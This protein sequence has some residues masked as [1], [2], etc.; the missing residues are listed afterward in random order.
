MIDNKNQMF[1]SGIVESRMD[2]LFL[3]RCRVR[4]IGVH[5]PDKTQLPTHGLPWA[6]PIQSITSAAMSGIGQAPVGP[7][8]GTWCIIIFTDPE[9]KQQ[10]MILGTIAGIPT[11]ENVYDDLGAKPAAPPSSGGNLVTSDGTPV[12]TSSGI[13]VT[14]GGDS[15]QPIQNNPIGAPQAATAAAV[16]GVL[17]T[18]SSSDLDKLLACIRKHESTNNY[19][20]VNSLGYVGGYQFGMAMLEDLGYINKGSW[21]HWAKNR[22][23]ERDDVWTGKDG[24]TT[25]ALFLANPGVQ[26]NAAKA[27]LKIWYSRMK[28]A[29]YI[30]D[31]TPAATL[32]GLLM[33]AHLKGTGQGGVRDFLRG[34]ATPDG[35]GTSPNKYYNAGFNAVSGTSPTQYPTKE[36]VTKQDAG[37]AATIDSKIQPKTTEGGQH[38]QSAISQDVVVKGDPTKWGFIDPTLTYPK[39]DHLN[40]PDT[41]RLARRQKLDK[42]I[43]GEKIANRTVGVSFANSSTTWEQPEIPY[44][45]QYPYNHVL[46]TES[47]HIMEFDDTPNSE[48]TQIYH[49]SGT[50]TETDVTGSQVTR[51]VGS[52]YQ[53]TE[54]DDMLYI[55][56]TGA[57]TIDG[58]FSIDV[59]SALQIRVYE[60]A[61]IHVMGNLRQTVDGD[62]D[63]NCKNFR[64]NAS[65][66][67]NVTSGLMT[68][69]QSGLDF[70]VVSGTQTRLLSGMQTSIKSAAKVTLDGSQVHHN[71]GI[72]ETAVAATPANPLVGFTP[73]LYMFDA[74]THERSQSASIETPS[75]EDIIPIIKHPPLE[76]EQGSAGSPAVTQTP[77]TSSGNPEAPSTA[78]PSTTTTDGRKVITKPTGF[79]QF[80]ITQKTRLSD[81][82]TLG[83]LCLVGDSGIMPPEEGVSHPRGNFSQKDLVLSL[84]NIAVNVLEPIRQQY[85]DLVITSGLRRQSISKTTGKVSTSQHE[86]GQAV[87]IQLLNLGK[88][89]KM[90]YTDRKVFYSKWAIELSKI[91]SFDQMLFEFRDPGS[92]WV[93]ISFA[94]TLRREMK[95]FKNDVSVNKAIQ[96]WPEGLSESQ[97]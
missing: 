36:T 33:V 84:Q 29:H 27:E 31:T 24:I 53:I 92:V 95:T 74:P 14:T 59:K 16:P 20:K 1:Y 6:V 55:K 86:C 70:N 52:K 43:V 41:N 61:Q 44:N 50:F 22:Y 12:T 2:P 23:T 68:H 71:T 17:G 78:A 63:I 65:E 47:G 57:I 4:V 32:A 42:T 28:K 49:T 66:T 13:P 72:S 64:M 46:S 94:Q 81:N 19:T 79:I 87:D 48:R 75:E 89:S 58:D 10:P 76:Y 5:S 73:D 97:R 9:S 40:E 80:P 88:G 51:V 83:Q 69:H 45:A 34:T 25:R 37:V 60:D 54:C 85:P 35:Y 93:H 82:F 62:I 15:S 39:N 56:G 18:L 11:K 7:V 21:A 3:G 96:I 90:S 91:I 26:D 67:V 38:Y 30:D 8:E 77:Q